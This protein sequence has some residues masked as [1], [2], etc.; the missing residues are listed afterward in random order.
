MK[1]LNDYAEDVYKC[2][3]CGLCQ[4][5][6]PV[7]EQTGLEAAVSRG[8]FTL[9]NGIIT[10]D[11]E[12]TK[13]VSS[14]LDLCLSCDVCSDFCPSG[15][16]AEEIL[17]AAKHEAFKK[18]FVNPVKKLIIY[19]FNS[20]FFLNLIKYSLILYRITGVIK[21]TE[22]FSGILGKLGLKIKLLNRCLKI[23]VNYKKF[24]SKTTNELNVVYFPG[25]INNYINPSVENAVKMVFDVNGINYQIPDF[26]CCGIP[27]RNA[28]DLE[29]FI[30]HARKNLDK[31]PDN[32]DYVITDC[33]SCG[34]VWYMY[35]QVL[36]DKYRQKAFEIAQKTMN[37]NTLLTKI[38]LFI[39]D[40]TNEKQV[41]TY[42]DPC[43][44]VRFQK[45]KEEPRKILNKLPDV[46]FIE[47]QDSDKCCG[48]SGNF[49]ICMEKISKEISKQ[50][51]CNILAT[52]AQ[53][54]STS[55]PSCNIG[56]IQGLLELNKDLPIFQPVELLANL[57]LKTML[58][59]P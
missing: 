26:E 32:I 1:K 52:N 18:G 47:M 28:G 16:E 20:N 19:L 39:P 29:S 24:A 17:T 12:F 41:V 58:N 35:A 6:C 50:K 21:F 34:S 43:H 53:I 25:C 11:I 2:T 33:A 49:F 7:F 27:A 40:Y 44:L 31:I 48:A 36:E 45:V 42:H 14:Y 54:V 22:L 37:I 51:A 30:K 4:S 5:V 46:D 15:I 56:I 3:K 9:L 38:D 13:K 10:K 23:N 57:Y 59:K 55:C 8:K